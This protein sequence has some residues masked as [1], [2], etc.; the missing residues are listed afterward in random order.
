MIKKVLFL[1]VLLLGAVPLLWAGTVN[2]NS[3]DMGT[4]NSMSVDQSGNV[5]IT[6]GGGGTLCD[7]QIVVT[8]SLSFSITKGQTTNPTQ[9]VSVKDGCTPAN[10]LVFTVTSTPPSWLSVTPNSGSGTLNVTVTAAAITQSTSATI[11]MNVQGLV[12]TVSKTVNVNVTYSDPGLQPA[13]TLSANDPNM[14]YGEAKGTQTVVSEKYYKFDIPSQC[15]LVTV[16]WTSFDWVGKV[17]MLVK[18]GSLPTITDWNNAVAGGYPAQSL[19]SPLWY[20]LMA[21]SGGGGETVT[22][23]NLPAGTYYIMMKNTNST[24]SS[25]K[26]WYTPNCSYAGR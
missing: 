21:T 23:T 4:L 26:V 18:A 6:T 12:G 11:T 25:F 7:E 3:V 14:W 9:V 1:V 20:N 2:V 17:D 16:A 13:P 5:I 15:N 10:N 22:M 24:S 8:S 19:T